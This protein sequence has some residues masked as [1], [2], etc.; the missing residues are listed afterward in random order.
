MALKN[1]SFFFQKSVISLLILVI[2]GTTMAFPQSSFYAANRKESYPQV[3]SR[4]G[5]DDNSNLNSRF[6]ENNSSASSV[7]P[8][9]T[10]TDTLRDPDVVFRVGTWPKERLPFWFLNSLHIDSQ[11][12]QNI[13]CL[14]CVNQESL[15]Q[16]MPRS[17]F[18]QGK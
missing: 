13:P 6:G 15:Q 10:E 9:T 5:G 7:A 3:L 12:R 8:P 14:N 18:A 1:V 11:R 2:T 4:F 16:P 17:P